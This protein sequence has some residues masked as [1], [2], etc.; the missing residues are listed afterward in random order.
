MINPDKNE[1]I[2]HVNEHKN[3]WV[4]FILKITPMIIVSAKTAK[5]S[6]KITYHIFW[7]I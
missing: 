3:D 5:D 4:N 7:S 6:A 1:I 2:L